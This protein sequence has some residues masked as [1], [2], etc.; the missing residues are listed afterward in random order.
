[1]EE[2]AFKLYYEEAFKQDYTESYG[3][4]DGKD[5]IPEFLKGTGKRDI[6]S[7]AKSIRPGV[8]AFIKYL[9]ALIGKVIK[10]EK[11]KGTRSDLIVTL[12]M[13]A[14]AFTVANLFYL[15]TKDMGSKMSATEYEAI[16]MGMYTAAMKD[17][18]NAKGGK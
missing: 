3:D 18:G 17:I 8:N 11:D 14:M 2:D 12:V 9:N 7:D 1:M 13:G 4:I 5:A 6:V 16:F 15:F 10:G